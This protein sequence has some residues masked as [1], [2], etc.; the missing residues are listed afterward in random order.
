MPLAF[1]VKPSFASGRLSPRLFGRID[2]DQFVTGLEKCTNFTIFAHGGA[3]FRSGTGFVSEVKNSAN[4]VRLFPFVFARDEAYAIE[5]GPTYARFYTGR[6]RQLGA[7]KTITGATQANPVEITSVAHGLSN[8]DVVYISGVGGM[9]EINDQFFTITNVATDTFELSGVDG[10]GFTAYTTGGVAQELLEVVTP[11]S[12][13]EIDNL[14]FTQSGDIM[15]LT[16]R[17][18]APRELRRKS[19]TEWEFGTFDF[20]DGPYYEENTTSTT[21]TPS[22]ATGTITVTASATAG[23]N[24]GQGFLATDVGRLIRFKHGSSDWGWMKITAWTSSTVVTAEVKSTLTSSSASTIWRLGAWSDT[25]GWPEAACFHQ[26]RLFF[27]RGQFIWGSSTGDFVNFKPSD[28][29]GTVNDDNAVTYRLGEGLIDSVEWLNSSRVLEVG[30][31]SAEFAFTGGSGADSALTPD[32]VR[33]RKETER[34]A[35]SFGQPAFTSNGTVFLNRSG[36]K[37]VNF[38]YSFQSDG[39]LADDITLLSEDITF[40]FCFEMAYQQEPDM[41]LWVVRSD[42]KLVACT[43][44]PAQQVV[45]WHDH[46]VGGTDAVVESICSIPAPD[47][48]SDDLW[49]VVSRTIDGSTVRYVEYMQPTFGPLDDIEDAWFVDSGLQYSG[50][51]VTTVS[52]L[53]HLEGETVAILADGSVRPSKVVTS[54]QVTI[55]V[56]AEKITVGLPYTG[57]MRLLPFEPGSLANA[58]T[59]RRSR[60]VDV[61]LQFYRTVL[62]EVG[63]DGDPLEV[64]GRRESSDPLGAP[65]QPR[66]EY[67]RVPVAGRSEFRPRIVVRQSNPL[68]CTILAVHPTMDI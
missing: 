16:V 27:A 51:A 45:A 20:E 15:Y 50:S 26:Q 19:A 37:L 10:T 5:M 24:D 21:L 36:R 25:D 1:P 53:D 67:E 17:T 3:T 47:G 32:S 43:F 33:A 39:Y 38:Y 58:I 18:K 63:V 46:E 44:N 12:S 62:A 56:A 2:L 31:G 57:E 34:G 35:Y 9:T 8:N 41:I 22:A 64:V 66:T 54:G 13:S 60:I 40:P 52:G 11:Y 23:I 49:L 61:G 4:A 14:Y 59:S 65:L 48:N 68:P 42:G 6:D 29:D 7:N 55:D 30:T 28:L